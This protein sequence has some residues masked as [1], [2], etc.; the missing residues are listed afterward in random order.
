VATLTWT[1]DAAA[2]T[3]DPIIALAVD[4]GELPAELEAT[5]R[6]EADS[7]VMGV[8]HE[9][10]PHVGVQFHPESHF[11]E[12]GLELLENFLAV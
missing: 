5:A 1:F 3:R 11:S 8:R 9:S 12:Y 6:T 2:D 7:V 4:H 10:R